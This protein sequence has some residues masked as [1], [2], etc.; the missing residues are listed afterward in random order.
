MCEDPDNPKSSPGRPVSCL[1]PSTL[2][3]RQKLA[4][5]CSSKVSLIICW[6]EPDLPAA[7]DPTPPFEDLVDPKT[8][9]D[10]LELSSAPMTPKFSRH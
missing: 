10:C 9:Q 2:T 8:L 6:C 1:P 3:L 4:H 5:I 7:K